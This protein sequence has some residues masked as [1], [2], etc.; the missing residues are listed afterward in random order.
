[1]SISKS[2]TRHAL[3]EHCPYA[4]LTEKVQVLVEA[5]YEA[6]PEIKESHGWKHVTAVFGHAKKAITAQ[7]PPLFA[8]HSMLVLVAALLHDVDD[9]KYFRKDSENAIDI[10]A[11]AGIDKET[12]GNVMEMIS[13]VSCSTNR[14]SV[15]ESV[16]ESGDYWR[17]IPRWSDRLEAVG[18]KGVL[19]CYQYS[20]E[21]GLPLSSPSSPRAV[22]QA[23]VWDIAS[24]DRFAKY[25]GDSTDMISHYYDKLLHVA[26]PPA[27]IVRNSYLEDEARSSCKELVEVCVRFGKTGVVDVDY[28]ENILS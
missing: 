12:A 11:K 5:F 9:H 18:A 6:H 23:E 3:V 1:M 17:L 13:H 7:N 21:A 2:S 28:I 22:T 19:R 16:R 10:M 26:C 24:P 20:K 25:N 15:P 8:R 4:V 27:E 14:N